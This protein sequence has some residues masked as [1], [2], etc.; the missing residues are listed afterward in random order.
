MGDFTDPKRKGSERW[1][2]NFF[3]RGICI[4][5]PYLSSFFIIDNSDSHG[6]KEIFLYKVQENPICTDGR[7]EWVSYTEEVDFQQIH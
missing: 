5:S 6:I 3:Y 7:T 4:P 2:N 1:Q